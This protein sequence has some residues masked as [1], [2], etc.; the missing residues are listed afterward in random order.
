[1]IFVLAMVLV[2]VGIGFAQWMSSRQR[3]AVVTQI[4]DAE[5]EL[6]RLEVIKR[7]INKAKANKKILQE[8]LN[9]IDTLNLN[10]TRPIQ[11]MSLLA[12]KIP[13]KMWLKSLDKKNDKLTLQGV[14][15]DDE[16]IA[17]FMKELQ[18]SK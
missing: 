6:K 4:R 11:I 1:T 3:E 13:E 2:L 8:K 14:A 12:S 18:Q 5:A 10:R 9:I 7:K 16:T 15:L 17:N